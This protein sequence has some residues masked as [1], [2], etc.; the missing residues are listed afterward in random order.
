MDARALTPGP[1]WLAALN[2]LHAR[3]EAAVLVTLVGVRGHAPREAGAKM[4]VSARGTWDSV[5]GGNLEA[6][7]VDRARQ[8]LTGGAAGP[9][10]LT[11]R[12]TD[13]AP[14]EYGRQCCGGEV[15]LLL[16]VVLAPR[17]HVALFGLGHVG[18]ELARLLARHPLT[19]HLVDSRAAQLHPDRLACLADAVAHVQPHHAPIPEQV[20]ADLPPGTHL[21]VFTHD[22]A[23][24]AA[25]LDAALRRADLG[26]LGL[27][28]SAAKWARFQAQLRDLGHPPGA[29]ARVTTPIGLPELMTGPHRKHPAVIALSVAAQLLPLLDPAPAATSPE[30]TP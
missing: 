14:N 13:R 4:L 6:T 11:L 22:H 29:L 5:G 21:L 28:G 27:I 17:A 20:L 16:D 1:P 2:A 8:L 12:L 19:L 24:D 30:R 26:H 3:G 7:A 23:E 10:L 9:E 15:T 25:I 18:L